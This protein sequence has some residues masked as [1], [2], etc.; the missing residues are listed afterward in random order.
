MA[1]RFDAGDETALLLSPSYV[2]LL[3]KV[4]TRAAVSNSCIEGLGD[5]QYRN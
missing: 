3:E 4:M 1:R 5:N 2:R